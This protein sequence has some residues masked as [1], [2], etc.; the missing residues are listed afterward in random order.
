MARC[1]LTSEKSHGIKVQR[2]VQILKI[3]VRL[4]GAH[5]PSKCVGDAEL[6]LDAC[7]FNSWKGEARGSRVQ[8]H[9]A[10]TV[11]P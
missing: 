10:Y 3:P 7:E 2:E 11:R 1:S 9:L 5:L 8:D 4:P 6:C